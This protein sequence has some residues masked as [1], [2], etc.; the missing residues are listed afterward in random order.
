MLISNNFKQEILSQLEKANSSIFIAVAWLTEQSYL[1]VLKQ[2]I[3]QGL[4]IKIILSASEWNLLRSEDYVY[5][6]KKGAFIH[7]R[8][9]RTPK[10][11]NFMHCKFCVID[12]KICISGSSNWTKNAQT[13]DEN[14]EITEDKIKAKEYK[15]LFND[16]MFE[17]KP[18]FE[19]IDIRKIKELV[20]TLMMLENNEMQP[21]FYHV[22]LKLE[23]ENKIENMMKENTEN[24]PIAQPNQAI[25]KNENKP[26]VIKDFSEIESLDFEMSNTFEIELIIIKS[27]VS[28]KGMMYNGE[29]ERFITLCLHNGEEIFAIMKRKDF[30]NTLRKNNRFDIFYEIIG[31]FP[32]LLLKMILPSMYLTGKIRFQLLNQEDRQTFKPAMFEILPNLFG[33]LFKFSDGEPWTHQNE[34]TQRERGIEIFDKFIKGEYKN[35]S[36]ITREFPA[37][38]I[39]FL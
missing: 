16:L 29:Y 26:I 18:I 28:Y 22:S 3:E 32:D 35:E 20:E 36:D 1:N 23:D 21:E 6:I 7:K 34:T 17:S 13:N 14:V 15:D 33:H 12:E 27:F 25:Q 5:L 37:A 30:T 8:G 31:G 10:N 24:L 11:G 39:T 4:I 19:G 9:E 2:K 38:K